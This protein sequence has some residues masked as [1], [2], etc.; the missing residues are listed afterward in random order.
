MMTS[1]SLNQL[2]EEIRLIISFQANVEL[3]EVIHFCVDKAFG[4]RINV[5]GGAHMYTF[6][7]Q[8]GAL[9]GMWDWCIVVF[10]TPVCYSSEKRNPQ[11]K[12][13]N[14]R[15][16]DPHFSIYASVNWVSTGSDNGLSPIRRQAIFLTNAGL[17]SY[18]P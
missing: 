8:N 15:I 6:L 10:V 5:H 4:T 1:P 11:K 14:Q 18:C 3:T 2:R 17:L 9:C 7:L 13:I 12:E 16:D